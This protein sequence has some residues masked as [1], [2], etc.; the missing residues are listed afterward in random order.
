MRTVS[1]VPVRDRPRL[2]SLLSTGNVTPIYAVHLLDVTDSGNIVPGIK[3]DDIVV[4]FLDVSHRIPE[5]V[6]GSEFT[7]IEWQ[8]L[9]FH[10]LPEAGTC[11]QFRRRLWPAVI[12]RSEDMA[13]DGYSA[14]VAE[15][16]FLRRVVPAF[17][18]GAAASLAS[19][20]GEFPVHGLALLSFDAMMA[21]RISPLFRRH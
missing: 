16:V 5:R 6:I 3:A 11:R 19:A 2:A 12:D 7:V 1:A 14:G 17:I 9:G 8:E 13:V 10:I 21:S 15:E 4:C 20:G 18:V